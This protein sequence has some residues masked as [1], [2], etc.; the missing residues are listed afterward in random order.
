M[1]NGKEFKGSITSLG[2]DKHNLTL[3]PK[4]IQI[5]SEYRGSAYLSSLNLT[6]V[7]HLA[8]TKVENR[9]YK[10]LA[11]AMT[12]LGVSFL[13]I[14][15]FGGREKL[16]YGSLLL[17]TG[18]ILAV[19][20]LFSKKIAI[21]ADGVKVIS[22]RGKLA[23]YDEVKTFFDYVRKLIDADFKVSIKSNSEKEAA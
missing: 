17:G 14:P 22:F 18:A 10:V 7:R 15:N 13:V 3:F 9:L 19:A 1:A 4:S 5:T 21:M 6:K 2:V 12:F 20:W 8:M 23:K 11:F 16:I